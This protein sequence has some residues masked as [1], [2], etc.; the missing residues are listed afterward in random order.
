MHAGLIA[1]GPEY[2]GKCAG[3]EKVENL[4]FQIGYRSITSPGWWAGGCPD[5][6]T[7][8]IAVIGHGINIGM[9]K[10]EVGVCVNPCTC[11]SHL[12]GCEV[13]MTWGAYALSHI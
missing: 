2:D 7:L 13:S 11:Q 12:C 10:W 5:Q 4:A 8:N 1:T 3:P 9:R 6:V